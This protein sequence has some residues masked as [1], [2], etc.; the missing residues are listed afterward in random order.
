MTLIKELLNLL[1]GSADNAP[2]WY[3]V[4]VK[5]DAIAAGPFDKRPGDATLRSYQ[6]YKQN[7]Y[8]VEF[9][10]IDETNDDFDKFKEADQQ[11]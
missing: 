7:E 2:S 4:R 1:E 6:W 5:D 8:T 3:V 11:K 9:G 10:T